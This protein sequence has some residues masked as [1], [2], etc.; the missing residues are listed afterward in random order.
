MPSYQY[1]ALNMKSRTP[2]S[3][4]INAESERQA[5]E[6]LRE[7]QLI[8]TNLKEVKQSASGSGNPLKRILAMFKGVGSKELL[9]F[10]RNIGIMVKNGIPLTEALLYF[11]N[12][13]DN[14]NFKTIINQI[15]KDI[16]GGVS[17]SG[18]L[19]KH[20]KV[21]DEVYVNVTQVG[22]SSG[23]L[24]SVLNRL[25]D[26]MMRWEK[27]RSKVISASVY[28]AIIL[29][30]ATV[31]IT[32]IL[33]IVLPTF[34]EIY[35]QMG[36]ELPLITEIM[37]A[38]SDFL[39]NAWFIAIPAIGAS[40]FGLVKL[41][42][43]PQGKLFFDQLSLKVPVLGDVV[44]FVNCSQ[45]ISTM[46]VSFTSGLPITEALVLSAETVSNT[47]MRE[48]F[49]EINVKVQAGQRLGEVFAQNGYFP[50]LVLL[51]ISTGEESGDLDR[52]L[53]NSYDFLEDEVN[54]KIDILMALMEP[55]MLM[56][57][58]GI[59]GFVALGIYLPLFGMYENM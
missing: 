8:P 51:M 40:V 43:T 50:D 56:V 49:R 17:F 31:V 52:M 27:I 54:Q 22:E 35:D 16:L 37:V 24:D 41:V 20:P 39:R 45:F 42:N 11:E 9:A 36:V 34:T 23:E 53:S 12:Y 15:R 10:T 44:R 38:I 30:I 7:L 6:K 57:L 2:T 18:A 55:V 32:L 5:R 14:P 59:V 28:P 3:G 46:S 1:K 48:S 13:L 47:V 29:F 25:N 26:L 58:G 19:R 33:V 21:F 4:M